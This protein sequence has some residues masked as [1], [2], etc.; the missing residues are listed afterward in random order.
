MGY[1]Q[2]G[3]SGRFRPLSKLGL[4][5]IDRTRIIFK[6][7]ESKGIMLRYNI[8]HNVHL[9]RFARTVVIVGKVDFV[10][11]GGAGFPLPQ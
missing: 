8:T 7:W 1:K 10:F 6:L 2:S 3:A 9:P 4:N 5:W 11:S